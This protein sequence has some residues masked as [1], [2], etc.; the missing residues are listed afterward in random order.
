MGS[1]PKRSKSRNG[2]L[3][4]RP[5][6]PTEA[7]GYP[8]TP[9]TRRKEPPI[10]ATLAKYGRKVHRLGWDRPPCIG[11]VAVGGTRFSA[12]EVSNSAD[13]QTTRH[14]VINTK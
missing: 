2:R 5:K 9:Q 12:A 13:I 8:I 10:S 3:W 7:I 6:R 1:W 4:A 11:N 14:G